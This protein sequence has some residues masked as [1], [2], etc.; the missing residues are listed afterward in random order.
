MTHGHH[1]DHSIWMTHGHWL[2]ID[3][4][5]GRPQLANHSPIIGLPFD[6]HAIKMPWL[7]IAA[8][9]SKSCTLS[10]N[11]PYHDYYQCHDHHTDCYRYCHYC[12]QCNYI[13]PCRYHSLSIYINTNISNT[14]IFTIG[15]SIII[16][17]AISTVIV[18]V[19]PII[20]AKAIHVL[21]QSQV[22]LRTIYWYHTRI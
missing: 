1:T 14:I 11:W 6:N 3:Q 10:T 2:T 19:S 22:P 7:V 8:A 16:A 13:Y 18:V 9:I 21:P 5:L 15:N 4:P 12:W 17:R 20:I